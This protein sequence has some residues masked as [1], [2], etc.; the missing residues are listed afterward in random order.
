MTKLRVASDWL[1]ERR[2]CNRPITKRIKAKP[3]ESQ[4]ALDS[5]L[6]I[7][8]NV[9]IFSFF[10]LFLFGSDNNGS[11]SATSSEDIDRAPMP[12][13]SSLFIFSPTNM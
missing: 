2:K 7:A 3:T 11:S 8:L 6:K 1:K 13:E 4:I 5:A 9:I 10:F 12:P